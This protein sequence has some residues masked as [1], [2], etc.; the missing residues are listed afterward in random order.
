MALRN[1]E[2]AELLTPLSLVTSI[3]DSR[4]PEE[5]QENRGSVLSTGD[6]TSKH[7]PRFSFSLRSVPGFL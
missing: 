5:H 1:F 7:L 3:A 4:C 6:S 2:H